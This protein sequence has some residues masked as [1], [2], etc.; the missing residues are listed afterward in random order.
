MTEPRCADV[1]ARFVD[2]IDGRLDAAESVR[3]HAHLE[4]CAGCR[5]R[6]ALWRGA[7]PGLRAAVPPRPGAMAVRRMEVEIA[8]GLAAREAV[9]GTRRWRLWWGP[10]FGAVAAAAAFAIWLRVGPPARVAPIGYAALASVR[11]AATVGDRAVAA[12]DRIPVGA[13]I[14][15]GAGAVAELALDQGATLALEGPARLTLEGSARD[16]AV[17]LA[18]GRLR[19]AVTHRQPDE[20]FA[21]ITKDLRVEVR[22]TK[23]A[24]AAAD[25]GSHVEVTEG[26][27]A[28]QFAD[29]RTTLVSA[30]GSA[31]SAVTGAEDAAPV[32]E[33]AAGE[34]PAPVGVAPGCGGIVRSC[35]A[36]ARAVRA[37]MRGGDAPRA[38]KMIADARRGAGVA[39]ATCGAAASAC[40]DEIRYLHAEALNQAGRLDESVDAYLALDRRA[41]PPAMRQNALYAAAQ[42]ERRRGQVAAAGSD[43]ERALAAAPRGAL[44]EEALVGAMESA[45]D[46]G[47]GARARALASRYLTE[48]P[49]GLA[50]AA[51]RRIAGDGAP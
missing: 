13:P 34:A 18:D 29:G 14:A 20:R 38:L 43:F 19:A 24:V 51:A 36:T 41:A 4:G 12:A 16:V 17:R 35:R 27:V 48:F 22:G 45:R 7:L 10:A 2:V 30:G 37:S 3:F 9:A 6:A 40:D 31:D 50:A 23:F 5:E 25:T 33:A 32:D 1:E 47:N 42:I 8:R 28:V 15:L 21:V 46:A 26:R 11:G 39:D 44:H 49:H